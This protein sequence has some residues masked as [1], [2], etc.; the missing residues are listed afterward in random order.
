MAD[1]A[2]KGR[3]YLV[4]GGPGDP[5]LV[6]VRAVECLR[7]ADVVVYD[8][9]TS[10]CLLSC[11]R[12]DAEM[13][14]AGK[15]PGRKPGPEPGPGTATGEPAPGE[16]RIDQDAINR[17]LVQKAQEG[18]VVVRLKGGDPFVFGRGGEEGEA[19][20]AARIPFEVVPGVTSAI[21]VPAYAGIPVTHRG[22]ASSVAIVSGREDP[23]K[24]WT[25][26]AWQRIAQAVDTIVVLMGVEEMPRIVQAL[27]DGGRSP[28]TAAAIIERGTEPGQRT[29]TGT[30]ADIVER[31]R[32]AGIRPPAITVV[33]E[34]VRL[35]E[36]LRWFDNR[37]LFGRRVLVTR[38]RTQASSL[39]ELLA[40]EGA[41]PVELAAIAIKP[42]E[43][44]RELDR[45]AA[46][47][48]DYNWVVF[49][50]ANGVDALFARLHAQ[51]CDARAFG[52]TRVCAIGPATA[53]A[54]A[55]QGI[56]ADLV[57]QEFVSEAVVEALA[58][59]G[60]AG[61]RVLLPRADIAG[62]DLVEGLAR[63]GARVRQVTAYRTV[64]PEEA[65]AE[66]KR[67][68]ADGHIDVVTFTSSSTVKNLV[69]LLKGDLRPVKGAVVACI[70]PVTARAARET[71]LPVD[72][73]AAE[74]TV[75]GL[76]R[77]LVEYFQKR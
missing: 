2:C 5:G 75:R 53:E 66:A 24:G 31:A 74:H 19:L 63:L 25:Q 13:H 6:T 61:A 46:S 26:V 33:G 59:A 52:G 27:R 40:R 16:G 36:R 39:V 42:V 9:L 72:I 49:T 37:P 65:A 70:G 67:L 30:L 62:E 1:A 44:T 22:V 11:A 7:Q 14:Y 77:A 76:V 51:G 55:R 34:V 54:L 28:E 23:G 35:R 4:G 3:V 32:A 64:A 47:V 58:K 68:L 21:A 60:I 41:E 17:L 57:P 56:R 38:A 12:P 10:P 73:V 20:A 50:S 69:M 43:D 18:K 15:T 71:G 45:V 8:R 29:V 48:G